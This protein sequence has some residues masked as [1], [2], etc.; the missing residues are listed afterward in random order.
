MA[1]DDGS[2]RVW[3]IEKNKDWIFPGSKRVPKAIAFSPTGPMMA[4]SDAGKIA[5]WGVGVTDKPE[6]LRI[7][8]PE[9]TAIT[10]SAN[11]LEMA[12]GIGSTIATWDMPT[13]RRTRTY[14]L[15]GGVLALAYS[16]REGL[17]A[18]TGDSKL[19][20]LWVWRVDERRRMNSISLREP[21]VA[22]ALSSSGDRLAAAT[23]QGEVHYWDTLPPPRH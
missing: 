1:A 18:V 2:V 21:A 8:G 3:D 5:L 10:F 6:A 13:R 15:S 4:V 16:D 23:V 9:A 22:V 11:G 17:I 20:K 12:A 14:S 7:Q 19:S